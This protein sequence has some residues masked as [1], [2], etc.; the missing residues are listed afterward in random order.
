MKKNLELMQTLAARICHD[1]AGSIGT[2]DN[3]LGL[4]DTKDESI[5]KQAKL[6]ANEESGN[7]IRK[8]QVLRECYGLSSS[9]EEMSTIYLS[10][11]LKDLFVNS[12]IEFNIH[13]EDGILCLNTL[14]AKIVMC[15]MAIAKEPS[16][17]SKIDLFFNSDNSIKIVAAGEGI[18]LKKDNFW[19]E[20]S[21]VK[22]PITTGNVRQH[23]INM[24]CDVVGYKITVSQKGNAIEYNI[25]KSQ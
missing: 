2:I 25:A 22:T 13:F 15:L 24:M 6:L 8:M 7:L 19:Q 12:S 20:N 11:S 3:C 18:K 9:E 14:L 23:Y 21:L 4:M 1:L 5:R 16:K 17:T 10:K